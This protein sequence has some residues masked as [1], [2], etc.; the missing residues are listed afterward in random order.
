MYD[1]CFLMF[2]YRLIALKFYCCEA[3]KRKACYCWLGQDL[4]AL[5]IVLAYLVVWLSLYHL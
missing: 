3:V 2:F 5:S 1:G 4:K